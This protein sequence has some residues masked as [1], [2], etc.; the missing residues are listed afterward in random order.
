MSKKHGITALPYMS[1]KKHGNNH[2][3]LKKI[4]LPL[5]YVQKQGITRVI[6]TKKICY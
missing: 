4:V 1:K 2:S 3:T 6:S 5:Y